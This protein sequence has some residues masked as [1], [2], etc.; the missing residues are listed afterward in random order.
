VKKEGH[1]TGVGAV[2]G[3]VAGGLV[4]NLFGHGTGRAA[5]TVLGAVG[6]GVAGNSV[7]KHLRDETD[8]Q[9]HVKMES[10]HTRYFTYREAPP[11]QQGERVHLENGRLIAG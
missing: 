9:V 8:Y 5:M 4:G 7:E 3:A 10:G 2:G 11:F 1:G 6:G